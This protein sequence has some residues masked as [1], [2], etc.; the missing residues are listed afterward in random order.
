MSKLTGHCPEHG[1][2]ILDTACPLCE[3]GEVELDDEG[4][5]TDRVTVKLHAA[6]C[7]L[8]WIAQQPCTMDA[9]G[10]SDDTPCSETEACL[11]EWCLPC[12]ARVSLRKIRPEEE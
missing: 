2:W 12:Y 6:I 9:E 1:A 5:E 7:S 11:T 8:M 4:D 10:S 3:A